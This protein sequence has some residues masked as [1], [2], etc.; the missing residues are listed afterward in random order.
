MRTSQRVWFIAIMH[1]I[2]WFRFDHLFVECGE[3]EEEKEL[4]T[5]CITVITPD[6]EIKRYGELLKKQNTSPEQ[7]KSKIL[8]LY[9]Q[10]CLH[11]FF[12]AHLK[13]YCLTD[14]VHFLKVS[15][16]HTGPQLQLDKHPNIENCKEISIEDNHCE[17]HNPPLTKRPSSRVSEMVGDYEKEIET[18]RER[19]Y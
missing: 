18:R 5:Y 15:A 14:T 2:V 6:E 4:R 13:P 17:D 7:T 1:L 8:H 16:T 9:R 19:L 11:L 3:D 12:N 10:N